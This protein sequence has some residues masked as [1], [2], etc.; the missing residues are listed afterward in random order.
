MAWTRVPMHCP[1]CDSGWG[2][3]KTPNHAL[4]ILVIM[5]SA[6]IVVTCGG[7][8]GVVLAGVASVLIIFVVAIWGIESF[9]TS[10]QRPLCD[11]CGVVGSWIPRTKKK[12]KPVEDQSLPRL[13]REPTRLEHWWSSQSRDTR[14]ALILIGALAGIITSGVVISNN[15]A[16]ERRAESERDRLHREQVLER[17]QREADAEAEQAQREHERR[18]AEERARREEAARPKPPPKQYA[19]LSGYDYEAKVTVK[20]INLWLRANR[21]GAV[22]VVGYLR[23]GA[24]VEILDVDRSYSPPMYKVKDR[25]GDLTGWVSDLFV[26]LQ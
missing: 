20:K 12:P 4:Y 16:E 9:V 19:I 14:A 2:V 3:K 24:A 7:L 6:L 10:M 23:H 11:N 22:P 1:A 5:G 15:R 13:P 18:L 17:R 21:S 8:M 25:H 26:R